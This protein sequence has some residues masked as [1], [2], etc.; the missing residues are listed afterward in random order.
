MLLLSSATNSHTE[1]FFG[2]ERPNAEQ[3]LARLQRNEAV[4]SWQA[5]KQCFEKIRLAKES[6]AAAYLA[7]KSLFEE[8]RMLREKEAREWD[9]LEVS[10]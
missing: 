7:E 8:A 4:K 9:D 3:R 1:N 2:P 6:K 10:A 5:R